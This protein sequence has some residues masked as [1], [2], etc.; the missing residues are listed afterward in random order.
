[1]NKDIQNRKFSFNLNYKN[2]LQSS[3]KLSYNQNYYSDCDS[4]FS[5]DDG[6]AFGKMNE[7]ENNNYFDEEDLNKNYYLID[8]NNHNYIF[9]NEITRHRINDSNAIKNHIVICGMHQ[10]LINFIL[11]LRNK[12]LPEKLLKWIVILSH[13]YLKKCMKLYVNFKK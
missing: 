2:N 11:P 12:Y 5:D 9:S 3:K 6:N 10:E 13:F 1:M 8:D 7:M 4:D